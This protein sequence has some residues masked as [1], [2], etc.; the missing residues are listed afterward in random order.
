[1]RLINISR[2]KR[3]WIK[4]S[5][6]RI[7]ILIFLKGFNRLQLNLLL[8]SD[9]LYLWRSAQR[10]QV[11]LRK[12]WLQIGN[13]LLLLGRCHQTLAVLHPND[14][15]HFWRVASPV[16]PLLDI[17]GALFRCLFNYNPF[18][19]FVSIELKPR[20]HLK[21]K[22]LGATCILAMFHHGRKNQVV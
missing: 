20:F 21:L 5:L 10:C 14:G 6:W 8:H 15:F 12:I 13:G 17:E 7:T 22:D 16:Q 11:L 9:L 18:G 1:M 2:C 19:D 3:F 4:L